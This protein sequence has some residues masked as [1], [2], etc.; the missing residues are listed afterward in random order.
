MS[1][2]YEYS[3]CRH[4]LGRGCTHCSQRGQFRRR[5][6]SR[7]ELAAS[8]ERRGLLGA[9]VGQAREQRSQESERV[10]AFLRAK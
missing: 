7:T 5:L 10:L 2:S 3:T 4:C 6:W 9:T 8:S 1:A